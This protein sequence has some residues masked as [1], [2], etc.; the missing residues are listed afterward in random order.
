MSPMDALRRLQFPMYL[1]PS[2]ED[3]K[4]EAEGEIVVETGVGLEDDDD[5]TD[6]GDIQGLGDT[7]RN[8]WGL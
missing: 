1:S 4:D 7:L 8:E 5:D 3:I 6:E 2:K